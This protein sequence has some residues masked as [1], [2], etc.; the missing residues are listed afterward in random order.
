MGEIEAEF[1]LEQ[2]ERL[3]KKAD[4]SGAVRCLIGEFKFTLTEPEFADL[5]AEVR[6]KVG[7]TQLLVCEELKGRLFA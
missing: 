6:E 3:A 2:P 1:T 5:M 7:F 4:T